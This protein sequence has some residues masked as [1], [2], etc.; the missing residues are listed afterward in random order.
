MDEN[1][2][3]L[4]TILVAGI[5]VLVLLSTCSAPQARFSA[6]RPLSSDAQTVRAT[7]IQPLPSV[8]P[9]PALVNT[10]A[11]V[12]TPDT[13]RL[14]F[15]PA[16]PQ[17][18]PQPSP[19]PAELARTVDAYL[20]ELTA[21]N[22]FSGAVLVARGG[23]VILSKG[24]GMAD[25]E[26]GI[27]NTAQTRFRLASV[28][29]QF[30]A[31]GIMI[32]QARG[33]LNVQDSICTYL[34]ECPEAWKP[35][36]V[37]NL[38]TH[39]S[40]IPNYTDFADFDV[41]QAQPASP[42]ELVSRFR[43]LPLNFMPGTAYSYGN[44][45]YVLLGQIIERVSGQPY[46]D[47]LRKTIFVPLWMRDTGYDYGTPGNVQRAQGYA[48]V[49]TPAV[50]LN[51]STLYSAGALYST[52]ED[53]YRWDQALY[54]DALIPNAL[55]AEMFTPFQS[56][57]AYGWTIRS[58]NGHQVTAHPGFMSGAATYIERVPDQRVTVIVLSN[59]ETANVQGISDYLTSLAS[60]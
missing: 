39:T 15:T 19:S 31:M 34:P 12:G 50:P 52:V 6:W 4:K 42:Q 21:G 32:L 8:T 40:G 36:T 22:A 7:P 49:G 11:V 51:T 47:F 16:T 13:I 30:T 20:N 54:S 59:L 46:E 28:T 45:G 17:P 41:T 2:R 33:K 29:K 10:A 25:A 1:V 27:P 18:T 38:L 24:Y 43:D 56:S 55:R 60:Q 23:Q 14:Q 58:L 48:T 5:A 35:V 9:G 37:R 53:M 26:Q 3:I 57:Y 44:S